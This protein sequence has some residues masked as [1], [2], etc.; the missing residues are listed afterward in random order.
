MGSKCLGFSK[1]DIQ[2]YRLS[3]CHAEVLAVRGF[4]HWLL[5]DK[6]NDYFEGRVWKSEHKVRL[7]CSHPPCGDASIT[8]ISEE[9][10][11]RTGAKALEQAGSTLEDAGVPGKIRFKSGRSDLPKEHRSISMSCSDKIMRWNAIGL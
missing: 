6:S 3:D 11:F 7:F 1:L 8:P 5:S 2:G 10:V 9:D 4:R